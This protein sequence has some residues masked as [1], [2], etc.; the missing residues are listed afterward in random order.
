[1]AEPTLPKPILVD[2]TEVVAAMVRHADIH[3]GIWQLFVEFGIT[4]ANMGFRD[5]NDPDAPTGPEDGPPSYILPTAMIPIKQ[6]GIIPKT[7]LSNISVDASVVNP[8]PESKKARRTPKK[9]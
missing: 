8:K 5:P 2:F 7:H 6:I 3:E 4:A 1:M 9:K